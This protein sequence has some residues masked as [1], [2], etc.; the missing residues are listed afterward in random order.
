VAKDDV[1]L[2]ENLAD[3]VLEFV[4]RSPAAI[5]ALRRASLT[6]AVS[7]PLPHISHQPSQPT[8][9]QLEAGF[10]GHVV[11]ACPKYVPTLHLTR[12][13]PNSSDRIVPDG[14]IWL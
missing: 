7:S 6:E 10:P 9:R 11:K 13:P 4:Y 12:I 8:P 14:Q 1:P 2:I 3:A 5:S